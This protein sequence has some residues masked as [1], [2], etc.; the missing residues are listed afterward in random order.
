MAEN[1]QVN[2]DEFL[3]AAQRAYKAHASDF[4][5]RASAAHKDAGE[6]LDCGNDLQG[7]ARGLAHSSA[8]DQ[9]GRHLQAGCRSGAYGG[10][11]GFQ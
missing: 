3:K 1:K 11:D 9:G 7:M 8:N 5:K 6:E 4:Q 2:M 10:V